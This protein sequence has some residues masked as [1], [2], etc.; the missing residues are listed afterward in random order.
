MRDN[1]KHYVNGSE[2]SGDRIMNLVIWIPALGLLGLT[3]L[4]LMFAFVFACD[5]V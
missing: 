3:G 5:K 4:G 1:G 2:G